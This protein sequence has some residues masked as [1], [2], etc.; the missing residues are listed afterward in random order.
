MKR[1]FLFIAVVSLMI[2][3]KKTSYVAKFDK[4]PQERIAEQ[5]SLVS[6]ALSA[7]PN[8][9]IA[10]LPTQAGGGYGFYISFDKELNVSM[11]GD[12]TATSSS[13]I[14]NSYYR[15]KQD[16][17]TELVFDTYNYI[18]ILNDPNATLGGTAKI[19]Y[20]SD[21]E[22]TF[23]KIAGDTMIFIGKKFRQ[24]FRLL[25][26][27]AAQKTAYLAG[28]LKT[29]IDKLTKYFVDNKFPYIDVASGAG[30]VKANIIP[31]MSNNL[32]SG[33]RIELT[34][35]LTDGVSISTAKDKFAF[36]TDGITVLNGGIKFQGITFVRMAWKDATTLAFYDSTGK[37]Y[38][39]KDNGVP[40]V[41]INLLWGSKYVGLRSNYKVINPGTSASGTTILN[42]FYNNL[43]PPA[44][45]FS[46]NY[47]HIDL[48][49]SRPNKR[50]SFDARVT[51]SGPSETGGWVTNITYTYTVNPDGSY[52]FT[53]F[54]AASG[55]YV[56]TVMTQLDNFL[57]NN[58][59]KFDYYTDNGVLYCKMSSVSDPSIVMTWILK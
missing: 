8:G 7:S 11:Y 46:F 37:E 23:D 4:L 1:I 26:A 33:K 14:G 25:K 44:L 39:V 13:V 51:Q 48:N 35:V 16:M 52:K 20:S 47:G 56:A 6:N 29:S 36:T 41:D 54:A 3:C 5:L 10:T 40:L 19:G 50:L 55:G 53:T 31:N 28:G 17:G 38:I 34:A 32:A 58:N 24:P 22:F 18:S 59:V 12:M 43:Q 49:W 42:S 2:S 9:W 45:G 57:K 30:T 27:T 15:I 21:V